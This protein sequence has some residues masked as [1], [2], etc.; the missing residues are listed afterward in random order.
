MCC[1]VDEEE[2]ITLD[3]EV[4]YL[5]VEPYSP[6]KAPSMT[7][8]EKLKHMFDV[9]HGNLTGSCYLEVDED[10]GIVSVMKDGCLC[11]S[12]TKSDL[13]FEYLTRNW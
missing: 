5:G 13:V 8:D 11:W 7:D 3:T 9:V 1:F 6:P 12:R 4:E 10:S 2:G